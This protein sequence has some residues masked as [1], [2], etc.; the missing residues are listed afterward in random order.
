VT[1][2][3]T[4]SGSTLTVEV[5]DASGLGGAAV[6]LR[7]PAS[8]AFTKLLPGTLLET[9]GT[10]LALGG[11][12][13]DGTILAASVLPRGKGPATGNG[14]L[15]GIAVEGSGCHAAPTLLRTTAYSAEGAATDIPIV[16]PGTGAALLPLLGIA[17]LLA[18][19][20]RS[21]RA[22]HP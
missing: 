3:L 9:H 17:S 13:V 7:L 2:S 19:L 8:C 21:I 18:F 12:R 22:R 15:L 4:Q 1:F 10:P 6:E 14:T 16:L 5:R 11:P 20:L